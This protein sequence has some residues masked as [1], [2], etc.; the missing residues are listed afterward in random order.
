MP[1]PREAVDHTPAR[2]Q[3]WSDADGDVRSWVEAIADDIERV[4][5]P[6]PVSVLLHGSLAMGSYYRPKS[7]VDLLVVVDGGIADAVRRDLVA[8]LLA[9]FDE[10]PTIGGLELTVVRGRDVVSIDHPVPYEAHFSE[11]WADAIRAGGCGPRGRD[12]DLAV[13]CAVARQ[14][15]VAL[16]GDGPDR[17][18]GP[19]PRDALVASVDEDLR[20]IVGERGVHRSPYYAVLNACRGLRAVEAA[21]APLLS[22]EEGARWGLESLPEV[23][24]GVIADALEC[25]R[26]GAPITASERTTHGHEW[27]HAALEAFGSHLA[28]RLGGSGVG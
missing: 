2:A 4:L 11:R 13:Q 1:R 20:W 7:D 5:D 16:R 6:R 21:S 15:G 17:L 26:S 24:H 10:R 9:R 19:V 23:H 12:S 27:D 18:I 22:K 3:H 28:D 14:C 8:R 25:Y